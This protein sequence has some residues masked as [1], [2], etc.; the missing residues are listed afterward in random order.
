MG[1]KQE[2][3]RLSLQIKDL[4]AR[5]G[6]TQNQLARYLYTEL[7][8]LDDE[9]DIIKFQEKLKKELQRPTTK[10]ERLIEYLSIIVRSSEAQKLDVVFNRY[11]RQDSIASGLSEA[12]ADIS[13]GIDNTLESKDTMAES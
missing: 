11:I 8:D 7:N 4:I 1:T 12:M 6:W 13:S 10:P 5:L 2:S 3:L 9:D